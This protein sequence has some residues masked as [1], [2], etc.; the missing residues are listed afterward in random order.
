[1]SE[2][3]LE[4]H[5]LVVFIHYIDMSGIYEEV[6]IEDMTYDEVR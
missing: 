6:E 4:L 3:R 5:F 2:E 1:V